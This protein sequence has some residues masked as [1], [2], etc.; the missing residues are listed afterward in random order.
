MV[1]ALIWGY[2][3]SSTLFQRHYASFGMW[4][5]NNLPESLWICFRLTIRLFVASYYL[6]LVSNVWTYSS[7]IL[8]MLLFNLFW[9]L[10]LLYPTMRMMIV[11]SLYFLLLEWMKVLLT[12]KRKERKYSYEWW[13]KWNTPCVFLKRLKHSVP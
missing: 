12:K 6:V 8:S 5:F 4:P 2:P 7:I 13:Q 1:H 11:Y 10:S 3:R 9:E